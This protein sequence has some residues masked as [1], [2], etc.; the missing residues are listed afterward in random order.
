MGAKEIPQQL[1]TLAALAEDP[2]TILSTQ[3]VSHNY[4]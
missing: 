2:G 4:L 3:M 1:R